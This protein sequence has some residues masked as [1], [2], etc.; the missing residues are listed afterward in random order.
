MPRSDLVR[1]KDRLPRTEKGVDN[2][3]SQLGDY[4]RD[5]ANRFV[6]KIVVEAER[7]YIYFEKMVDKASSQEFDTGLSFSD[8]ARSVQMEEISFPTILKGPPAAS[9]MLGMF[10]LIYSS[11]YDASHLL[12]GPKSKIHK[13]LEIPRLMTKIFGVPVIVVPDIPDDVIILTGSRSRECEPEDI[14][15]LVKGNVP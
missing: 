4:L 14:E 11:G 7:Q 1:V 2:L 8:V 12:I 13:W 6:Q 5:P 15:Y 3:I 10:N 9:Y